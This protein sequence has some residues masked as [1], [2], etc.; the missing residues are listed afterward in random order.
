M[1]DNLRAMSGHIVLKVLL[2]VIILTFVLTGVS[3]YLPG[4]H[5][6]YAAKVNGDRISRA[7]LDQDF[8]GQ[9]SQL[10]NMGGHFSDLASN[11]EYL[12][13]LRQQ[14]LSQLID[15]KLLNQYAHKMGLLVSDEQ[16]TQLILSQSIFQ[17]DGKFN[18]AQYNSQLAIRGYT[19]DEF[20]KNLRDYMVREQLQNL[21]IGTDFLLEDEA[22]TLSTL[23]T[24]QRVVRQATIHTDALVARQHV[25]K[26]EINSYYQ[27]NKR[28]FMAPEQFRVSYIKLDA[29]NLQE[30]VHQNEIQSWYEKHKQ[31]YTQP[32]RMRFS[33]IRSATKAEA[34][35]ILADLKKGKNFATL[36]KD[37][38]TDTY[39]A[40]KGGDIGWY[41]PQT[42]PDE[43]KNAKVTKKGQIT[44]V[45]PYSTGFIIARLDDI[46][47]EQIKPLSKIRNQ[48]AKKIQHEKALDTYN[49]LQGQVYDAARNDNSSLEAAGRVQGVKV[50]ETGWFTRDSVPKELNFEP[51]KEVIFNGSLLEDHSSAGKNSELITA[52]GD[53]SF[54]LRIAK[55]KPEVLKP[56]SEVQAKITNSLLHDKAL[57]EART[58]AEKIVAELTAGQGANA[59]RTSGLKFSDRKILNRSDSSLIAQAAFNLPAPAKDRASYGISED[60]EGNVVLLALDRIEPGKTS[61]MVE[62]TLKSQEINN[63]GQMAFE[64]LL[65]NLRREAKIQYGSGIATQ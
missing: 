3:N 34:E 6:D 15:E 50:M 1:M 2:G 63:N 10:Q 47:P 5:P 43:L 8:T 59:L 38:S 54:V 13:L 11:E 24:E 21:I 23:L 27:Q 9:R 17:V 45:I 41:E 57:K 30:P 16:I 33:I 37:K 31:Q 20:V 39:T 65:N 36:A 64:S 28:D 53:R 29:A 18:N 51:V 49:R 12:K 35:A 25:T 19:A 62:Q 32:Q 40:S 42:L 58:Q 44:D 52:E 61:K 56:L 26:E 48:L 55:H 4:S 14:V 7:Q 46:V 22:S 60:N